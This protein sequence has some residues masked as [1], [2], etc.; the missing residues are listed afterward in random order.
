MINYIRRTLIKTSVINKMKSCTNIIVC[1]MVLVGCSQS[2]IADKEF[3]KNEVEINE[4]YISKKFYTKKLSDNFASFLK[5]PNEISGRAA[6]DGT[7]EE[8]LFAEMWES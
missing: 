6:V 5:N 7:A 4:D 8:C 3:Q 1:A 2:I